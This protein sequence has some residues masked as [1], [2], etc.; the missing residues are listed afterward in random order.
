MVR[1][2]IFF[3]LKPG[4]GITRNKDAAEGLSWEMRRKNAGVKGDRKQFVDL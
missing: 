2:L 1:V 4:L 3:K